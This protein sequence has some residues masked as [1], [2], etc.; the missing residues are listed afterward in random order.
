MPVWGYVLLAALGAF[1]ITLGSV[2]QEREA[3]HAP[4]EPVARAGFL[5]HLLRRPRWV[6]G[7]ALVLLGTGLHVL[8]LSGAPLTV[9]QPIGVSG[10][11]FGIILIALRNGR[12]VHLGEIVAGVGVTGGLAMLVLSFPHDADP[13][14]MGLETAAWLCGAVTL[15]G[16]LVHLTARWLPASPRALLL[17]LAAGLAVGTTSALIRVLAHGAMESPLAL[18]SWLVPMAAAVGAFGALLLQ[19]AYRTGHFAAAYATLLLSDPVAGA[20]IGV[21]VLGE[22]LPQDPVA[23][24][25]ALIGG[26]VAVL[27]TVAL[28]RARYRNPLPDTRSQLST[29]GVES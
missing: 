27:G 14:V 24:V 28:S 16:V 23:Q 7:S 9:V 10:L 21:V 25:L 4:G 26:A 6:I 20:G 22:P 1:F 19:N 11:V 8:A 5:M 3:V 2:Q 12:R 18:L 29:T 15:F 13:P 17:A